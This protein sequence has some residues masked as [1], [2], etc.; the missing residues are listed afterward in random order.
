MNDNIMN[1]KM[2]K[3]IIQPLPVDGNFNPDNWHVISPKEYLERIRKDGI[4][5]I[6]N[7]IMINMGNETDEFKSEVEILES[8]ETVDLL[9]LF[10]WVNDGFEIIGQSIDGD[11]LAATNSQV[12]IIPEDMHRVDIEYYDMDVPHFFFNFFTGKIHSKIFPP[13]NLLPKK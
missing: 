5:N 9:M 8:E 1:S 10:E 3:G 12:M 7:Y 13:L 2:V 11:Y 4:D 6:D